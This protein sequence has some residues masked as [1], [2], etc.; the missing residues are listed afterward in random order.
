MYFDVV[1]A[2][3]LDG[4]KLL[5]VFQDHSRGEVD[6]SDY[7]QE[8]TVFE[9]FK[10]INFFKTFKINYGTLTWDNGMIDIAPE[11]LYLKATGKKEIIWKNTG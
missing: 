6:L 1:K 8:G 2:E 3:Y 4:Y 9:K 10:D 11:T 7:L 5:L